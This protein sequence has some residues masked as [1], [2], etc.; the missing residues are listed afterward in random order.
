LDASRNL[1]S[2][3]YD[4]SKPY[5]ERL[6]NIFQVNFTASLKLNRKHVTHEIL[7]DFYNLLNNKANVS[8]YYNIFTETVEYQ[9]QLALMPNVMYRIHF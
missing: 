5:E 1:G 7:F 4:Y 3:V 2:V 6:N 8:E 9:K